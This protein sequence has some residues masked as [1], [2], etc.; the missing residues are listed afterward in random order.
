MNT[1]FDVAEWFLS[2]EEM[3]HKKLQKLCYYAQAWSCAI[4]PEPI[5]NATFEAWVHGPVCLELYNKYMDYGFSNI[6]KNPNSPTSFSPEEEEFLMDVWNTYGD[7]TAN[8][9]EVLTHTETP[10]QKPRLGL[11]PNENSDRPID[12]EDM[13]VYYRSIYT[14]GDA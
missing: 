5:T 8:S 11:A 7:M 13:A 2:I 12:P 3:T 14:G 9:L 10:W 6:P 4:C 1:I